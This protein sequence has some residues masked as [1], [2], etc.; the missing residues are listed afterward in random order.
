[1]KNK[2]IWVAILIIV[3]AL[4]GYWWWNKNH[5]PVGTVNDTTATVP[6]GNSLGGSIYQNVVA[7]NPAAS[8]PNTNPFSAPTNPVKDSYKNP[9]N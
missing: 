6:A 2:V 4:V 7:P 1:M 3:A 9:F 5:S 8:L